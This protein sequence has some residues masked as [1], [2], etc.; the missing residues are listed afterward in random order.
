MRNSGLRDSNG[1]TF[2]NIFTCIHTCEFLPF[3]LK[4]RNTFPFAVKISWRKE[5]MK[6]E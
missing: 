5:G 2:F 3:F 1:F 6:S 4:E